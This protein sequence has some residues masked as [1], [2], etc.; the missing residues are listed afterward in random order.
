MNQ[1]LNRILSDVKRFHRRSGSKLLFENYKCKIDRAIA[2][3]AD[4]KIA[5]L[6]LS[7]LMEVKP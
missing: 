2:P 7:R 3:D 5:V 6:E 1:R 4:K